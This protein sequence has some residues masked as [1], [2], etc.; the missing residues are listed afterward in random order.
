M[1]GLKPRPF[2]TGLNQRFLR[3]QYVAKALML[4][5]PLPIRRWSHI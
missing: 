3:A 2:K 1:A 5:F 4:V